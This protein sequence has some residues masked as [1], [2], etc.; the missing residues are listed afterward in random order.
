[1]RLRDRSLRAVLLLA[2]FTCDACSPN[3]S[4]PVAVSASLSTTTQPPSAPSPPPRDRGRT[5][6][7]TMSFRGADWLTRPERVAEEQPDRMLAALH[8]APGMTVAD[9]GTGV[10]YHA[11]K[12]S[13]LVGPAGR[14]YASDIQDEMLAM[15]RRELEQRQINNVT[16][17]H[18]G[19]TET[20]LPKGSIDVALMVDVYHELG[21]P[22][23]F[24]A[25]LKEALKPEGRL[26]LV[27][28][29]GEDPD[30]PIKEEH[31]MTAEQAIRELAAAGFTLV[32][33]QEFLPWQH[34]L[35]FTQRR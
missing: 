28:F 27:E 11:L 35:I 3:A 17:V 9:I 5:P 26:A 25:R 33:R 20:G 7:E 10:G 29:R 4:P 22:E 23:R 14:V 21:Q 13:A 18:S 30:V 32:E 24:L 34:I 2:A 19:D 15:L 16:P 8:L 1:M 6:A 12:M 31:K